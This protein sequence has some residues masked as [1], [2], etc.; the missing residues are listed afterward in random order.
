MVISIEFDH[1]GSLRVLRGVIREGA[2]RGVSYAL[3]LFLIAC[4]VMFMVLNGHHGV[5]ISK[6]TI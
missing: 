4:K 2:V 5:L 6:L 1:F 3:S